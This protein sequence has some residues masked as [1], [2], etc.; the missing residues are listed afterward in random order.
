MRI[1][2]RPA[3]RPHR[4][5]DARIA[6][7]LPAALTVVLA[8]AVLRWRYP[9]EV[10]Y[11]ITAASLLTLLLYGWDKLCAVRDWSRISEKTL[12]LLSLVGGWPGA[13][14]AQQIFNHK[15]SKAAFRR[16]FWLT[17]V[18]NCAVLG[19]TFGEKGEGLLRDGID[20]AYDLSEMVVDLLPWR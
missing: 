20:R 18:L 8:A 10:L 3:F 19:V 4:R 5:A 14:L 12:H 13:M 6:I 11:W 2:A 7:L 15:T 9:P 16:I 17:V 1:D